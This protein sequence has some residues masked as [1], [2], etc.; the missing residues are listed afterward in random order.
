MATWIHTTI[1]TRKK[2]NI[3]TFKSNIT[4]QDIPENVIRSS[5]GDIDGFM[6]YVVP[7]AK[8]IIKVFKHV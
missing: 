8:V 3:Y 1:K 7:G 2:L 4:I 6:S 5:N